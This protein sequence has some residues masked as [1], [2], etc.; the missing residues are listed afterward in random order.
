MALRQTGRGETVAHGGM[1]W[2]AKAQSLHTRHK[3]GWGPAGLNPKSDFATGSC[4]F[5]T[6]KK[7]WGLNFTVPD[8]VSTTVL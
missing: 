7:H 6:H 5:S 8:G 2:E 3:A 4:I 1:V